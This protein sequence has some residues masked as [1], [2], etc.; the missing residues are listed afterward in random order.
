MRRLLDGLAISVGGVAA[1]LAVLSLVVLVTSEL[2]LRRRYVVPTRSLASKNDPASIERGRHLTVA[3]CQ[4]THCHGDGLEGRPAVDD[5]LV[6]RLYAP[7]LTAGQGGIG[8]TYSDADFDRAIRHAVDREGR[9]LAIMPAQYLRELDDRDLADMIAYLR[10]VPPADHETPARKVGFLSRLVLVTGLAE[11]LLPAEEMDHETQ[12]ERAPEP[13]ISVE[14]GRYLV[15]LGSC[16]VCH[17]ADLTGGAHPL[18][19]PGEPIPPD[20]GPGGALAGWSADDFV[21]ALRSGVTRDGRHLDHRYM[22][23]P[24]IGQ[25][26]DAE[27]RAIWL[28]VASLATR[29]GEQRVTEVARPG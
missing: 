7:N 15:D 5:P 1:L 2:R 27:L 10:S 4:C 13:G 23:W 3:V 8:A 6:G 9:A 25:L 29:E 28:Y 17:H 14:Y 21:K 11:D 16:R 22:P 24:Y 20:L 12:P 18:A 19:V 26:S